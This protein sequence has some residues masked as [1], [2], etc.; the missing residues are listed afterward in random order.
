MLGSIFIPRALKRISVLV[1]L[2]VEVQIKSVTTLRCY[3]VKVE[4]TLK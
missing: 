4:D 1:G 3:F 2:V